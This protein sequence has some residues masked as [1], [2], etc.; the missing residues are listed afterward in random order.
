M[1]TVMTLSLALAGMVRRNSCKRAVEL[2][3]GFASTEFG[4]VPAQVL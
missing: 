3:L 2:N 4:A 1:T